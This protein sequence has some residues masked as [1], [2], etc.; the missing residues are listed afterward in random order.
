MFRKRFGLMN[1]DD[2]VF[3]RF[4]CEMLHPVVRPGATGIKRLCQLFNQHLRVDGFELVTKA[5]MLDRPLCVARF[6]RI[7]NTHPVRAWESLPSFECRRAWSYFFIICRRAHRAG[8]GGL[9]CKNT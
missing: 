9:S 3:L 5:R 2:E 6:L 4:L 7:A 1:G 8:V